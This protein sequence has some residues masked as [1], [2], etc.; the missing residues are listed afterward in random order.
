[1]LLLLRRELLLLRLL[2]LLLLLRLLLLLLLLRLLLRL[3]LLLLLLLRLLL[4][5]RRLLL[6]LRGLRRRRWHGRGVGGEGGGLCGVRAFGGV[7]GLVVRARADRDGVGCGVGG[8]GE[9]ADAQALAVALRAAVEFYLLSMAH[10]LVQTLP[11][12]YASLAHQRGA[13]CGQTS[14]VE[15]FAHDGAKQLCRALGSAPRPG[16]ALESACAE[17]ARDVHGV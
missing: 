7:E 10:V 11:S 3:L 8:R 17:C 12:V 5:R 9:L 14:C 15:L 1:M 4:R 13:L 16:A 2:L 6:R